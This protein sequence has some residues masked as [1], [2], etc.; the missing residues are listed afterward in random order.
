MQPDPH[1]PTGSSR[2]S[3][4]QHVDEADIAAQY[5]AGRSL[6]GIAQAHGTSRSRVRRIVLE[7]GIS[8]RPVVRHELEADSTWWIGTLQQGTT[9]TQ[10]ALD[11]Q[12]PQTSIRAHLRTL[13]VRS[14]AQPAFPDWL[15]RRV[16]PAGECR[17]WI[18]TAG[19]SNRPV[20]S[21]DGRRH[22]VHRLVWEQDQGP[23]PP[24]HWVVH[25]GS[26]PHDDCVNIDHLQ[27][28][29]TAL[30]QAEKAEQGVYAWGERHWNARL[31]ASSALEI[32]RSTDSAAVLA[33]RFGV[34]AASIR[35]IKAGR[36]WKQL[37]RIPV[38]PEPAQATL[39]DR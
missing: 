8:L 11:L 10:L 38:D 25:I 15:A 37:R 33:D 20:T 31:D 4:G 21:Y 7:A 24:G 27:L 26:C 28:L 9:I 17:R 2:P 29:E 14:P 36:R 35:A 19:S 16:D 22:L 18:G 32:L 3:R 1:P 39:R 6:R 12:V 5:R 13:G 30:R 23:I 34:S